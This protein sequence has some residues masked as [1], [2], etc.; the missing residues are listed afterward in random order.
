[1]DVGQAVTVVGL[2][3][4]ALGIAVLSWRTF[5]TSD[6]EI[7]KLSG[8]SWD[9]NPYLRPALFADRKAMRFGVPAL[10][11]GFALQAVGL[12]L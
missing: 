3:L 6:E 7:G 1:M 4:D 9:E 11:V 12:F 8:T 2:A 10:L 5:F